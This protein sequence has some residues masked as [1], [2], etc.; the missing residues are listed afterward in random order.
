[1]VAEQLKQF[2]PRDAWE[3]HVDDQYL[4]VDV[5]EHLAGGCRTWTIVAPQP[6]TSFRTARISSATATSSSTIRVESV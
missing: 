4:D 6:V 1:M 5:M 2:N 3:I